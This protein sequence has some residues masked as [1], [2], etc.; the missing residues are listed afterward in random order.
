MSG[1]QCP[2][3]ERQTWAKHARFP[4]GTFIDSRDL[5]GYMPPG[6]LITGD[7]EGERRDASGR[8]LGDW[9]RLL[10]AS[11]WPGR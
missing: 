1:E 6:P 10:Q 7:S 4:D 8:T 9:M 5:A 3:A 11:D 2:E